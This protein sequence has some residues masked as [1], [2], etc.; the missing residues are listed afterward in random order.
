MFNK[1]AKTRKSNQHN[2]ILHDNSRI[3]SISM[4]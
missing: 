4:A 2:K 1:Q 3:T